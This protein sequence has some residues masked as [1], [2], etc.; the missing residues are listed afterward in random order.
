MN[1]SEYDILE[2]ISSTAQFSLVRIRD[3]NSCR[4]YILKQFYTINPEQEI[5]EI[6]DENL[7]VLLFSDDSTQ[8][9]RGSVIYRDARGCSLS[10]YL[11]LNAPLP[12]EAFMKMA[13][14][15]IA[16]LSIFHAKGWMIRNLR[17][18]SILYN[19]DS[20]Q[21]LLIDTHKATRI[22]KQQLLVSGNEEIESLYYISPEQSGRISCAT[23]FRADYYTLGVIFYKALT[24]RLPYAVTERLS[25]MHSIVAQLPKT[26]SSINQNISERLSNIVMRLLQKDPE[27]R[28]Q[29]LAALKQDLFSGSEEIQED[30]LEN[31]DMPLRLS[32]TDK[33]TG[34]K[35]ILEK[36]DK[37]LE[38]ILH[39]NKQVVYLKGN[40]GVGKTRIV[41]EFFRVSQ[42]ENIRYISAKF[43]LL[44]RDIPFTALNVA[45]KELIR[46]LLSEE[47]S[48][49]NFWKNRLLHFLQGNGQLL[50]TDIPEL[51]LIIG[52]QPAVQELPPQ[53]AQN[54]YNQTCIH[55]MEAFTTDDQRLAVFIDDLQWADIASIKLIELINITST[56]RNFLFIGAY[57]TEEVDKTHPLAVSMQ[58]QEQ[59]IFCKDI[60]VPPLTLIDM[61]D[62]IRSL[63]PGKIV[64]EEELTS[65]LF[66]KTQGNTYFIIQLIASFYETKK[67]CRN[68]SGCW[69]WDEQALLATVPGG[70]IA[71]ILAERLQRL[72]HPM[73][74]V[75]KTAACLGDIFDF[76]TLMHIRK[77]GAEPVAEMLSG[78]VN[79]GFILA[80]D[81]NLNQILLRKAVKPNLNAR[82]KFIHDA[83]R[84]AAMALLTSEEISRANL[85]AAKYKLTNFSP[86]E[87]Q[88]DIF[89][90]A[91][92]FNMGASHLQT[93]DY[94]QC[95]EANLQAGLRA[96][97]A[98]AF[99]AAILY[100][101]SGKQYGDFR[102]NYSSMYQ[103]YLEAAICKF[104]TGK[105]SEAEQDLDFLLGQSITK[106]DKLNV[107]FNKSHLYTI[108]EKKKL[109]IDVARQG[110]A[111]FGR[112][113]PSGKMNIMARLLYNLIKARLIF[114]GKDLESLIDQKLI[115]DK[116]QER[117]LEFLLE[118][119]AP[120]Y[121]YD[122]N[123]FAWNTLQMLMLTHKY[124]NN[125][126]ASFGYLG[127][128]MIISQLFGKYE[129][130]YQFAQLAIKL[131][132]R[133]HY[134]SLKWKIQ[135]SYYNFVHHWTR[136]IKPELDRIL[137]IENGA[138]ANGD[139][140][141][142]GY[143]IFIYHQ[144]KFALGFA[145]ET[146]QESFEEY[147]KQV[148]QRQ[149][150][151]TK[152][153]LE[154]YYYA[155]RALRGLND[156]NRVP[157]KIFNAA[158]RIDDLKK[159]SSYSVVACMYIACCITYYH[160]GEYARALKHY[161]EGLDYI[162]FVQQRYEYAE[163]N[164]YGVLICVK[165]IEEKLVT[166]NWGL[167]RI[168]THLKNLSRWKS[169]CPENFEPQYLIAFA[170]Y[171]RI[172]G[173][174]NQAI[175]FMEKGISKAQEYQFVQYKGLA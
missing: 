76:K 55:L 147:L 58:K 138:F 89:Y 108:Q 5:M 13:S 49:L 73:L 166:R 16:M 111:L 81:E 60:E 171:K 19:A 22:I 119:A 170:E 79:E 139:P 14:G 158:V 109:S 173:R 42:K 103:F 134:T 151:E 15:L 175:Q 59:W 90:L 50:I 167:K 75:L 34:R 94:G 29:S 110:Y 26:P 85:T 162:D 86:G 48:V 30:Q 137:E 1:L 169:L 66:M 154:S 116:E 161:E 10:R 84:Q 140:L 117:F 31:M 155:I 46:Q 132:N 150:L 123:L 12:Q 57:R 93:A 77:S 118:V 36:L 17:P 70:T 47:E 174:S 9:G 135:L 126:V 80:L 32:V 35:D 23:D 8:N 125:G 159:L 2:E 172:R 102:N 91:S 98:S 148:N 130:G 152:H 63:L 107:L 100:F 168:H 20:G 82:F 113:L 153:F 11:Q 144:K 68:S 104:L 120:I 64:R 164:F 145:L 39:G 4:L 88:E 65:L 105:Y 97:N 95:R 56:I 143:A 33:L 72:D 67:I 160:F 127:F 71:G 112:K 62:L 53:E 129:K 142:A 61:P 7:P 106:L 24:A 101:E 51:S 18:E 157:G 141:F 165:A 114:G 43:D 83:V 78:A 156:N 96:K 74:E 40:S 131:N 92:N 28:Y 52:P 136:P 25:L 27:A 163:F 149:D 87:L 115:E 3:R 38:Q 99:E 121:Q 146:L 21:C 54:R 41:A 45:I 6:H 44:Q 122:Q 133:L 69:E 128:G 37:A 124:G